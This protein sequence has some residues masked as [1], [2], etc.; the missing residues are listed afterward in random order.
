MMKCARAGSRPGGCPTGKHVGVWDRALDG[1][2]EKKTPGG[3]PGLDLLTLAAR[4][5]LAFLL[6]AAYAAGVVLY[7]GVDPM[8]PTLFRSCEGIFLFVLALVSCTTGR[9]TSLVRRDS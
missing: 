2:T 4:L 8:T 3:P 5:G 1:S 7:A 9:P 6:T